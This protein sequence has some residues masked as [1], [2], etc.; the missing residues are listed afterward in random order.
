MSSKE[1]LP[2]SNLLKTI[3]TSKHLR[4]HRSQHT[5]LTLKLTTS[6]TLS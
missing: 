3:N 2:A 1:P 6:V 4:K 5:E